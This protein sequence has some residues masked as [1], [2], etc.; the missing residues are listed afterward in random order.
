MTIVKTIKYITIA[1]VFISF[2][3]LSSSEINSK[4][5]IENSLLE[6]ADKLTFERNIKPIM[7]TYCGGRFCHHGK[8]SEWTVYKNIKVVV[9]N[10]SFKK[11]VIDDKTMPKRKK[12]PLYEYN[13][14]KTWLKQGAIEK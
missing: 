12:L 7:N 8:K 13:I 1:L 6:K 11:E 2:S 5:L 3:L 9:D 4:N 10:G 14:I